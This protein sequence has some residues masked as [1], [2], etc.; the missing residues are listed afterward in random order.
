MRMQW[1]GFLL[2]ALQEYYHEH[3]PFTCDFRVAPVNHFAMSIQYTLA[4]VD[5]FHMITL[6]SHVLEY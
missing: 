1:D 6:T 5:Y 4:A 2:S 3:I